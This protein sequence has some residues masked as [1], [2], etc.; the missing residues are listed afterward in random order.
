MRA[1]RGRRRT[2]GR[3]KGHR[4]PQQRIIDRP[5]YEAPLEVI[6]AVLAERL[7]ELTTGEILVGRAA[8]LRE[9]PSLRRI[10]VPLILAP[11]VAAEE[12]RAYWAGSQQKDEAWL[13][14]AMRPKCAPVFIAGWEELAG[15][16]GGGA[17]Q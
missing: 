4:K 13:I 10:G 6:H 15:R 14:G 1:G 3:G 5:A 12:I 9:R 2:E 8:L 17:A 11:A 7:G 16:R